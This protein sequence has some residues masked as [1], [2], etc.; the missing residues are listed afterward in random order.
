LGILSTPFARRAWKVGAL[1]AACAAGVLLSFP[2]FETPELRPVLDLARRAPVADV[3]ARFQTVLFG[4]P[5]AEGLQE[6]GFRREGRQDETDVWAASAPT[7]RLLLRWPDPQPRLAVLDVEPYPGIAGQRLEVALNGAL[8]SEVTLQP[9]RR[10]Y[11]VE[12]PEG[13]Q[14]PGGNRIRLRIGEEEAGAERQPSR[15]RLYSLTV[16]P[17]ADP[18]VRALAATGAPPV[19]SIIAGEGGRS[20]LQSGPSVVRFAVVLPDAA[21]LRFAPGRL[22]PTGAPG[23][24]LRVTVEHEGA[25]PR[26]LWALDPAAATDGRE[27]RLGLSGEPGTPVVIGF[28]VEAGEGAAARAVWHAPRL[29]GSAPAPAQPLARLGVAEPKGQE[30]DDLRRALAGSSVLLIVLDAA[31][32]RHFGC[33]GYGRATTPDIDR[34]AAEGVLFERAYTPAPFTYAAMAALWTSQVPDQGHSE[35]L[36][37]G[38]GIMPVDRMTLAEL[39][40]AN[41]VPAAAFVANPSAGTAFGLERGFAEFNEVF[42]APWSA[43]GVPTAEVTGQALRQWLARRPSGRFFAYVHYREPHYPYAPP[44]P[45]D[46]LFEAGAPD[47]GSRSLEW[48]GELAAGRRAP[49][50]DELDVLQR[51][52]DAN[53]AFADREIGRLRAAM[54][55]AGLWDDTVVILTADHGEAMYEHGW[56]GHNT[57]VY[58]ESIRIPLIVRFPSAARVAPA[59]VGALTSLL[60]IGPTIADVFGLHARTAGRFRGRTLLADAVGGGGGYSFVSRTSGAT[61]ALVHGRHKLIHDVSSTEEE[62]FDLEADPREQTDLA[63]RQ[64][65]RAAAFRQALHRWLLDLRGAPPPSAAPARLDPRQRKALRALGY[66]R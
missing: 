7:A 33:Y 34:L 35:W 66:L 14:R 19:L 41:D 49:T 42:A 17:A 29:W 1:L 65:V 52:Y 6:N 12:L 59:R 4:T 39:L 45:F 36:R 15:A 40:S 18:G 21:E 32:A 56:V 62:L 16:G 22:A 50:P 43:D 27:V 3:R 26:E 11:A 24:R 37:Y 57:Q 25:G 23:P 48:Q 10:R 47:V 54:E 20:L 2:A 58:E 5:A 55:Q 61:F 46:T 44:P 30:L 53:L 9:G 13:A 8:M 31:G 64:P 60:D 51:L 63:A 38:E 28:H